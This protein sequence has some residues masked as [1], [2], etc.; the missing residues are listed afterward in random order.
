MEVMMLCWKN[1]QIGHIAFYCVGVVVGLLLVNLSRA[2]SRGCHNYRGSAAEISVAKYDP[3]I[4]MLVCM[5]S[6]W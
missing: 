6:N 2:K 5:N 1:D 4:E 3:K